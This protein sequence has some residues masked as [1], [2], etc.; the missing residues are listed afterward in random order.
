MYEW[1]TFL[2]GKSNVLESHD[3]SALNKCISKWKMH[4]YLKYWKQK[5][6]D[7]FYDF[8]YYCM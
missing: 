2:E 1:V 7:E 4:L 8:F 3:Q 6:E 5:R